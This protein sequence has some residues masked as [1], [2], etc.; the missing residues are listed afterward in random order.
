MA[1]TRTALGTA[2]IYLAFI[3]AYPEWGGRLYDVLMPLFL[4]GSVVGLWFLLQILDLGAKRYAAELAFLVLVFVLV[5]YTL[6]QKSG[7]T[8]LEQWS[9]GQR[10]S[11]SAARR[12]V[13]R[14]GFSPD[15]GLG[16]WIVSLF[17]R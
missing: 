5:G 6:P 15:D 17:P 2:L 9:Q 10:P 3:I 11:Q 8:P 1:L 16:S 12:G 14:L 13:T 7:L 4:A